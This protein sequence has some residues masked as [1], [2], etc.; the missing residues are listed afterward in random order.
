MRQTKEF[1]ATS[2]NKNPD[3]SSK[4]HQDRSPETILSEARSFLEQYYG[5]IGSLQSMNHFDRVRQVEADVTATGTYKLTPEEMLY[6]AKMA[7]RNAARC[8]G[9]IQ[10]TKL[11]LFD[12]Q[13]CTTARQMFEAICEHIKFAINGGNLR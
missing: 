5:S 4:V 2:S 9:R 3:S 13:H 6:G 11:T 7:W 10:W 8:I 1:L 12:A